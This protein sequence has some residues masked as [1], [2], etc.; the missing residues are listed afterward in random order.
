MAFFVVCSGSMDVKNNQSY[1]LFYLRN[2]VCDSGS[3][4]RER[5][6]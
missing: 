1:M 6:M 3:F 2:G 5:E 4:F